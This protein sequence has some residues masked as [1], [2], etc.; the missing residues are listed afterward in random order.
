MC[1]NSIKAGNRR[2]FSQ[3][4]HYRKQT[5]SLRGD[6]I[7]FCGRRWQTSVCYYRTLSSGALSL[8]RSQR[9]L[10]TAS[11]VNDLLLITRRDSATGE[12]MCS[13]DRLGDNTHCRAASC[14]A[15]LDLR[16]ASL[17]A[18]WSRCC[19]RPVNG[20][21]GLIVAAASRPTISSAAA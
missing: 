14:R 5:V 18:G 13:D 3:R 16:P 9:L 8:H 20:G 11:V 6:S 1:S 17:S 21:H 4:H 10:A 12:Q 2:P 7:K 15:R 19:R